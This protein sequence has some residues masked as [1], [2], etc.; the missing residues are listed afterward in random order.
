MQLAGFVPLTCSVNGETV[1][2]S[3]IGDLIFG[4]PE[5]IAYLS[6]VLPP[7]PGDVILTGTPSGVG[8]RPQ[9]YLAAGDALVTEVGGVGTMRHDCVAGRP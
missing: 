1:Q 3:S 9:R 6:W 7:L 5:M 8:C 4:V 2:Q